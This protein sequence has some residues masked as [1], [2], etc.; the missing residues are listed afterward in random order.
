MS[1]DD[2]TRRAFLRLT[3]AGLSATAISSL[4]NSTEASQVAPAR[5]CIIGRRRTR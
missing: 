5:D 3:S 2:F 1:I 4:V